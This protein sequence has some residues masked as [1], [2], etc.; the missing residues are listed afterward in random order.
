MELKSNNTVY[1]MPICMVYLTLLFAVVV[2]VVIVVVFRLKYTDK[3][4][5]CQKCPFCSQTLSIDT[6]GPVLREKLG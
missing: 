5:Q 6:G 3:L 2:V 1:E 4:K